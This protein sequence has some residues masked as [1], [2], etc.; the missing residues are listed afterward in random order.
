[1]PSSDLVVAIPYPAIVCP[2]DVLQKGAF[3]PYYTPIVS[4]RG[5]FP[6]QLDEP[7]RT[8]IGK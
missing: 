3:G 1:M 5:L 4:S 7:G 2:M 6:I 8:S